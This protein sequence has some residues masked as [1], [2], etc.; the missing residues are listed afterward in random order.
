M[1]KKTPKKAPKKAAKKSPPPNGAAELKAF[2]AAIQSLKATGS[3][4]AKVA[5]KNQ[6]LRS[7]EGVRKAVDSAQTVAADI[8][9]KIPLGPP[10]TTV[11]TG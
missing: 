4:L 9:K 7:N 2:K 6:S 10:H 1:A 3:A 11:F 5:K 8:A